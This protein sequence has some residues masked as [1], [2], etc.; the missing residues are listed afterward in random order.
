MH[1][2]DFYTGHLGANAIVGGSYAL[3]TGAALA[4]ACATAICNR[5]GTANDIE[6]A[7]NFAKSIEGVI[8]AVVIYK[9]TL[10]VKG[11]VELVQ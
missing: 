2:A 1:I 5:I 3:A 10:G 8:G 7:L 11:E 6:A 9:D 4:D